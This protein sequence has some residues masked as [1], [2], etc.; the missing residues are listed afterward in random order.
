MFDRNSSIRANQNSG[1]GGAP[2]STTGIV[3][4]IFLN[5]DDSVLT[6]LEIPN[7]D[8]ATY[9]GAIQY[10][11]QGGSNKGTAESVAF[12]K[13]L[14]YNSLPTLN[15]VVNIVS[16]AGGATYYERIGKSPTPN[17]KRSLPLPPFRVSLPSLP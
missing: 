4:H 17:I 11:S 5:S 14:N 10:K 16:G 12:P 8:R 1:K 3:Y 13:N 6:D 2:S 7:G 15:E 9:I